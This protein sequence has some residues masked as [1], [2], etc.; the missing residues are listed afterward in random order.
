MEMVTSVMLSI[1][2]QF[3]LDEEKTWYGT[4]AAWHHGR[5]GDQEV[6]AKQVAECLVR[7][8]GLVSCT[9]PIVLWI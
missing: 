4:Q 6:C 5:F 3:M 9:L 2:M 1:D 7:F 8:L